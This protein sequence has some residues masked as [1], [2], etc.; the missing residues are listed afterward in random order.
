MEFSTLFLLNAVFPMRTVIWL[1]LLVTTGL[2]GIIKYRQLSRS[3]QILTQLLFII[4]INEIVATLLLPFIGTNYPFY[5]AVQIIELLYFGF[6]FNHLLNKNR[7]Q[8]KVILVLA[9][10]LSSISIYFSFFYQSLYSFPSLGSVL[11]SFFVVLASVL[12]FHQM[13]R[14]PI[15]VPILK[16]SKFWFGAGSLFFYTITFFILGFFKFILDMEGRMPDW[17]YLL[18]N[19]ANYLLYTCYFIA[20]FLASK[21]KLHLI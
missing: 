20:I 19:A 14:S 5:H 4:V 2:L 17:A 11:L 21:T 18:L 12:L 8:A 9:F 1:I 6:I 7:V 15:S 10:V 16:Q 13:I 3:F